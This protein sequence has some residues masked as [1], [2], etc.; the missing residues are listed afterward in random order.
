MTILVGWSLRDSMSGMRIRLITVCLAAAAGVSAQPQGI[1]PQGKAA[2]VSIESAGNARGQALFNERCAI[3]HYDQSA[4][5]KMG[6]GLKG[7]YARGKFADGKK[8]DDTSMAAWI[9]K[10]GKDMPGLK[11]VLQP[12]EIRTLINYL[13]TL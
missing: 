12:A 3:C 8:V 1:Q 10:G 11:D 6:P 4:A 9:E 7:I 2:A 13:K 5:Q